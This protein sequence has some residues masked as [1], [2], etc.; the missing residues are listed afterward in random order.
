MLAILQKFKLSPRNNLRITSTDVK[1]PS[2][3]A[4]LDVCFKNTALKN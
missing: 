3:T 4:P 2:H 1:Q